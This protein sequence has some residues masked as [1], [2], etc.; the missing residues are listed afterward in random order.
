MRACIRSASLPS[1]L[2]EQIQ[3]HIVRVPAFV[4]VLFYFK[5]KQRDRARAQ[6]PLVIPVYVFFDVLLGIKDTL[7]EWFLFCFK[8]IVDEFIKY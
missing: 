8:Y 5:L 1:F 2:L 7:T 4:I 6:L 3:T